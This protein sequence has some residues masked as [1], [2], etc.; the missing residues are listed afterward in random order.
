MTTINNKQSDPTAVFL[1]S[2]V[3][4]AALMGAAS[5][6]N[7]DA[8]KTL[9]S[10]TAVVFFMVVLAVWLFLP[11][12]PYPFSSF[13]F[14]ISIYYLGLIASVV[15]NSEHTEYVDALKM[16][17]APAFIVLGAS[18]ESHRRGYLWD[19]LKYRQ[20]Y[21]V[22]VGLPLLIWIFQLATGLTS[23]GAGREVAMF[24]N[25]NNAGLYAVTLLAFF[26]VLSGRPIKDMFVF[27]LAG[28]SFGTLGV[29]VAVLIAL[30]LTVGKARELKILAITALAIG[31]VYIIAPDLA[32][33]NRLAPVVDTVK[34][35]L[36]EK[37]NLRTSTYADL[38]RLLNTT[39]LSFAFRLKHWIDLI[40]VFMQLPPAHWL[41][42]SG[43][44]G[45]VR[46]SAIGLVPHNDYIRYIF[47]CG[48]ITFFGFASIIFMIVYQC[49]RRWE[50]VPL[51]TVAIYFFSDNLVNNYLAMSIFYFCSGALVLRVRGK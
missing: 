51:V 30:M 44:G 29:L 13:K 41:L 17:M 38:V 10:A 21:F 47:E 26:N 36:E 31:G 39:D 16:F 14:A 15:F 48:L 1:W 3:A 18:F 22:L 8:L 34:Y 25:K 24:A 42:G 33:L 12:R 9:A 46:L 43:V 49:G 5:L 11:K 6:A 2:T 27:L 28:F 4:Y 32:T 45:S 35:L 40:D 7:T 23:L 20:L 37:I 50:N 19:Q